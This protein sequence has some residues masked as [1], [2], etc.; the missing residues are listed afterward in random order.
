MRKM[1]TP[2]CLLLAA[3][4]VAAIQCGA[5]EPEPVEPTPGLLAFTGARLITG[6]GDAIEDGVLVV[7][8]G[9]VAAAGAAGTVDVP[10]DAARM[11]LAGRTIIP[12]LINAHGH[13]NNV[14]GLEADP[15]FYTEAHV[16]DQLALYARYGVTTVLSLGGGGPAGMA[17]RDRQ[18]AGLNRARLYLSGPVVNPGSVE[19]ATE[20]VNAVADMGAD[21][22]KI[23]VDDNLGSTQKM[24]PDVFG[25]VIEQAHAR[26][27]RVAA[28]L[29]YL[30]DAK[31]LL[32]AGADL[33]AHSVRDQ[34]V[35]DELA[36]L[37]R[38]HD[39]CY[40]P[41]LMRE[42]STFV[43]EERPDWFD[44]P[45]FLQEVDPAVVQA[46]EAPEYQQRIRE[47]S[48]AQTYKVALEQA[49]ENLKA[50][51]DAG[52]RVA[53]GTDTGPAAR[54]Q[55]YFEHGELDLMVA[56]GLTP[57]QTLVAATGDAARCLQIDGDVGTL[58]AG[59]WADFVVLGSN[60]LDDI[61]NTRT[62]ESVWIAGNQVPLG[63]APQPPGQR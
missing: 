18:D 61:R 34:P 20:Q 11:D 30:D 31:A 27:L 50:L 24:T 1:T 58:A 32:A 45:F 37:L 53:M 52:V 56:S 13:V 16:E 46:L 47:S 63:P 9:R 33:I 4:C 28:H 21:I 55:G 51:S 57:M 42:V 25:A 49:R 17:V 14:R 15:A 22:V 38:E 39:V 7:R 2:R 59:K 5:P 60:P 41:T 12:G 26:G 40:C 36:A 3:L 48:S 23:R 35:D 62:I 10:A 8:D 29:Y 54:F 43:Y 44:D 19:E 6:S